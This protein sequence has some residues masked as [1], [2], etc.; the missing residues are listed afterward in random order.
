MDLLAAQASAPAID[1][2]L[3]HLNPSLSLLALQIKIIFFA[4]SL[5]LLQFLLAG[6]I[7]LFAH[8]A[9]CSGS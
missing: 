4:L 2:Y 3:T 1:A 9:S 8:L 6:L 7:S 5:P